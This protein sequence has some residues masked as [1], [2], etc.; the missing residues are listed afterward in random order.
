M[1][2]CFYEQYCK[3][4]YFDNFFCA[5]TLFSTDRLVYRIIYIFDC[6]MLRVITISG[7]KSYMI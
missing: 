6:M 2:D 5:S 1:V 4:K 3:Y 7:T